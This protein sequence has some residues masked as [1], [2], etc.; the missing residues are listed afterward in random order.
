[1]SEK[2]WKSALKIFLIFLVSAVLTI[3][4]SRSSLLCTKCLSTKDEIA[5]KTLVLIPLSSREEN[6]DIKP[7]HKHAHDWHTQQSK[8][9]YALTLLLKGT[10]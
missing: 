2:R 6:L 4:V 3:T 1:M 5:W 7:S 9:Y 10:P 8:Q